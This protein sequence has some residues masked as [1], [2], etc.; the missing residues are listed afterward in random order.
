MPAGHSTP[1]RRREDVRGLHKSF[2]SQLTVD[3]KYICN[4]LT[5]V[6]L[7]HVM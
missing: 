5:P 7:K 6:I 3:A 4:F 2:S 1:A